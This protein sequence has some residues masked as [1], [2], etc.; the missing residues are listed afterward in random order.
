VSANPVCFPSL[1]FLATIETRVKWAEWVC[2]TSVTS[3]IHLKF[4]YLTKSG[5]TWKISPIMH[6]FIRKEV[7]K[8]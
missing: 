6:H 1:L 4:N 7:L 3:L 5:Q 2:P 8:A